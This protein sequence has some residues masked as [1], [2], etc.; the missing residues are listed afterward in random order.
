MDG[1]GADGGPGPVTVTVGEA[2]VPH[3]VEG[4]G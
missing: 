2:T 4:E 1:R 3:G